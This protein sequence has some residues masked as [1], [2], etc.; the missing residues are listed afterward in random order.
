MRYSKPYYLPSYRAINPFYDEFKDLSVEWYQVKYWIDR[1]AYEPRLVNQNYP[2]LGNLIDCYGRDVFKGAMLDKSNFF[3][4]REEKEDNGLYFEITETYGYLP[5]KIFERNSSASVNFIGHKLNF[6]DPVLITLD[7]NSGSDT[8]NADYGYAGDIISFWRLKKAGS[9][10]HNCKS[11]AVTLTGD[12]TAPAPMWTDEDTGETATSK[13]VITGLTSTQLQYVDFYAYLIE[14]T[15]NGRSESVNVTT[16]TQFF[17]SQPTIIPR[18]KVVN[19]I[20]DEVQWANQ[21]NVVNLYNGKYCI[22]DSEIKID[23]NCGLWRRDIKLTEWKI[24]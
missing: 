22:E 6:Q 4:L 5:T 11:E 10:S 23:D 8:I 13:T 12:G 20:G 2:M 9:T 18:T 19:T 15:F 7:Y 24:F 14:R 1:N 16:Q 21:G 3:L 17:K